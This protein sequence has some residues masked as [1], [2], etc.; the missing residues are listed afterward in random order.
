MELAPS[1]LLPGDILRVGGIGLRTRR[2][3]AVLSALGI[4]I[5]IAAMVAVLALSESSKS[6]LIATLDRL[7]TN[8]LRVA[9]G[10]TLF[11]E[12]AKLPEQARGMIG[13]IGPVDEVSAV[14]AVDASVRRTD[15][16]SEEETGGISVLAAD[17][18]LP[19]TLGATLRAGAFLNA[20][21]SRYPAVVLGSIAAERLGIDRV[22]VDVWLGNQWFTVVGILNPIELAPDLD[23]SALVGLPIAKELLGA[24]GSASTI[25]VR[26]EPENLDDVRR[27]LGA[28]ANPEHPEEVE[29][30]RPSDALEARAAAKTAF[31]SLFL[32]LGAVALLVGGVGIANVMVISVLERR[33]EI[34]LRRALGAAKG[35]IRLQFLAESLMLAATGGAAGVALGTLITVVYAANRGWSAVVPWYVPF[36]G[37]ALAIAIGAVAGLYPAMRAARLAPT[38]ALRSA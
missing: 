25:Y 23:R 19:A 3:R 26:A 1:R 38:E 31:T 2:L 18:D 10:Q 37:I 28:T 35:H 15:Y 13:R 12:D 17:L 9:P 33:S 27:V 8:L 4:A 5:G 7:G 24:E 32:G 11:G 34:G 22:G 14:E 21:S 6:G 29:V 20:A 36:G 30:S 16:I